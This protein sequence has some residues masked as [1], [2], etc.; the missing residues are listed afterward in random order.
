MSLEEFPRRGPS[1]QTQ[2]GRKTR[3][4]GGTLQRIWTSHRI[5]PPPPGLPSHGG[6]KP[7]NAAE[8][9]ARYNP[10]FE[11]PGTPKLPVAQRGPKWHTAPQRRWLVLVLRNQAMRHFRSVPKWHQDHDPKVATLCQIMAFFHDDVTNPSRAAG[12]P[13]PRAENRELGRV[14][15]R[16]KTLRGIRLLPAHENLISHR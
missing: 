5:G 10:D 15:Q 6:G 12:Q 13:G 4:I 14:H 3:K 8:G 7:R 16:P 11:C 9:S 2:R 1:I